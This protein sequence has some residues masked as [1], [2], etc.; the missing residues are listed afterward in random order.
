MSSLPKVNN[1]K[2]TSLN[3]SFEV[4]PR[5]Y[6]GVSYSENSKAKNKTPDRGSGIKM[7][8]KGKLDPL[9]YSLGDASYDSPQNSGSRNPKMM[10]GYN[11]KGQ[12]E[13]VGI[14]Y[15]Q[16]FALGGQKFNTLSHP[17]QY[18]NQPTLLNGS[19]LLQNASDSGKKNSD[20]TSRGGKIK[21]DNTILELHKIPNEYNE[22]ENFDFGDVASEF[23]HRFMRIKER[24][25]KN[26][27]RFQQKF[28]EKYMKKDNFK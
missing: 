2:H 14:E 17:N 13:R 19:K 26:P 24:D 28:A 25:S 27:I 15:F 21:S 1:I 20:F 18:R 3:E 5:K 9:N 23:Y 8:Y 12:T 7:N 11:P 22:D 4:A 10:N 6:Y 16:N